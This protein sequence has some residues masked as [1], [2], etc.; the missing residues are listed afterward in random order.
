MNEPQ[1]P[2]PR[3]RAETPFTWYV[4]CGMPA[5]TTLA[6]VRFDRTFR[7]V[8]A[9]AEAYMVGG[10]KARE[11]FGPDLNYGGPA[12]AGI[13]YGHINCLGSPLRFPE[14]SEVAH[15]PIYDSLAQGIQALQNKVDWAG[16]GLMPDYLDLWERLKRAFP[17]HPITSAWEVRGHGF[18][19]DLYDDPAC[20]Q[21][22]LHLLTESIV[23]YSAFL[24][25]V[26][27]EPAFVE[28]S[29]GLCDDVSAMVHPRLWPDL[30]LPFQDQYFCTQT[31]GAR[32][33]HIE[34]LIPGHLPYLDELRLDRFDPSVSPR[35]Q[36]RDLRDRCHVPFMWRL[37]AMQVRDLTREQ[38]RRFVFEAVADGASGVM[39]IV[40][41]SMIGPEDVKKIHTFIDA[42]KQVERLLADDCQRGQLRAY[43]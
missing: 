3:T 19:T 1:P 13:S 25:S 36:P 15:A 22:F 4:N 38:I 10:P 29:V 11:M 6:G 23:S 37:N 8:D 39:S 16:A 30:V 34:D 2:R 20:C 33:A 32:H 41:R 18:F 9:I 42:A 35:L 24:R 28:T 31:S 40:S 27:G 14:N 7:D 43:I 21:E 5:Y 12:W 26:N 17:D